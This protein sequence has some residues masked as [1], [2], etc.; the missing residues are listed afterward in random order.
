MSYN[1]SEYKKVMCWRWLWV[2]LAKAQMKLGLPITDDMINEMQENIEKIDF[3]FI[4]EKVHL[5]DVIA[6]L[7]E[8]SSR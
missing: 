1:F 3:E 8:F 2:Y 6:H 4:E 7:D 5:H